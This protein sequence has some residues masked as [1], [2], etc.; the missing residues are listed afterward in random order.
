MVLVDV[1]VCTKEVDMEVMVSAYVYRNLSKE[2]MHWR[3]KQI[4]S[5]WGG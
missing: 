5:V 4:E 3:L 2:I 1:H